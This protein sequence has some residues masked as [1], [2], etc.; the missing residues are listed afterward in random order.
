MLQAI[1]CN[2]SWMSYDLTQVMALENVSQAQQT[3]FLSWPLA[4][5]LCSS[6]YHCRGKS[7][8][9]PAPASPP[10]SFLTKPWW[11]WIK[12]ASLLLHPSSF[13]PPINAFPENGK[14]HPKSSFGV[15]FWEQQFRLKVFLVLTWAIITV[16]PSPDCVWA[17][18]E[19]LLGF[20]CAGSMPTGFGL[21]DWDGAQC[22]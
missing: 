9:L 20:W 22:G 6:S 2:T 3:L 7:S 18:A 14:S 19:S 10:H 11:V 13:P 16:V 8:Q 15:G 4:A 21:I 1:L 12:E 5:P 17:S